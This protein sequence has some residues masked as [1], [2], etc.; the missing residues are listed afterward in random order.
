MK[1]LKNAILIFLITASYVSFSQ[2][3]TSI[4]PMLIRV[5]ARIVSAA[6]STGIPYANII[7]NRTHSGT[8]TNNEGYFS[9]EMLNIDSL[10]VTSVG[11]LRG[12]VTVPPN[13]NGQSVL[14]FLLKPVNYSIGE[15]EVKGNKPSIDLG[16]GT[17]KP[18]DIA[19][20]LRGDSYNEKPPV[21]AALMNPLSFW[22]YYLGKRE[23]QKRQVREAMVTEQNWKMYSQY[24]NKETIMRITGLNEM[25]TDTFMVWFNSQN[26]L[27]YTSNEY[28]V[29][30]AI[31]EYFQLYKLEGY[32]N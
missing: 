1:I 26:I 4:D 28:Q 30:S 14:V 31:N 19:P 29:I 9:M 12:I 16:L 15:V 3:N 25:E 18:T 27:P 2:D 24:Y 8:I 17:G 10:I 13:Y 5:Q 23:K 32:T 7:N 22:Q 6:D 11:Y 21:L 20:E